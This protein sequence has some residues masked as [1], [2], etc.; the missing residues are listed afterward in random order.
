MTTYHVN[1][2]YIGASPPKTP[3]AQPAAVDK[4]AGSIEI[5]SDGTSKTSFSRGAATV[6]TSAGIQKDIVASKAGPLNAPISFFKKTG[7]GGS[8]ADAEANP[9]DYKF[10]QGGTKVSLQSALNAGLVKKVGDHY[11]D[12]RANPSFKEGGSPQQ[13]QEETQDTLEDN[14]EAT[15]D[16][17]TESGFEMSEEG[18]EA[19]GKLQEINTNNP[20]LVDAAVTR[21]V[22]SNGEAL[23]ESSFVEQIAAQTGMAKDEASEVM[24]SS[25]TEYRAAAAQVIETAVPG[26]DGQSLLDFVRETNPQVADRMVYAQM[27]G[28]FSPHIAAANDYLNQL[29][30]YD[31]EAALSADLGPNAK[32]IEINGQVMVDFN[33]KR[34]TWADAMRF[35]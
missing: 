33:G 30:K 23:N 12:Y 22:A 2:D 5:R 27:T 15:P 20:D 7:V 3:K 1:S 32:A 24:A 31:R 9:K 28:D 21:L 8:V 18:A 26:L 14:Q 29:P 19:V 13:P 16:A 11:Y 17:L 6:D 34:Y 25:I 10:V 35:R 4:R